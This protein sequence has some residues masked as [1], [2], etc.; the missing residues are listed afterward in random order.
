VNALQRRI[1]SNPLPP[2]AVSVGIGLV[3]GGLSQYGFLAVATHA[4]GT[5]RSAPL[6]T[7]WAL[8]VIIGPGFFL[9]IEQEIGSALAARRARGAGGRPV[10]LRAAASGGAILAGL[11]VAAIAASGPVAQKLFA[12]QLVLSWALIAG[13]VAYFVQFLGR[14]TLAGNGRFRPY[15]AIVGGEGILRVVFCAGLAG[16]GAVTAG[17]FGLAMVAGSFVAVIVALTGRRGLLQPGPP[18][19]WSEISSALGFLLIAS[20]MTQFLLSVGTVAV[21]LLAAPAQQAAAGRFLTSRIIAYIPIFLFQAVQY[22]LLPKLAALAGVGRYG[23]FVK[24]LRQILGL[25][26][27]IGAAAVLV[28]TVVGPWATRLL[29]GRGFELTQ[30]DFL[31]LS[32]SCAG[33]MAAQVLSQALISLRGFARVA[34]GW[35]SGGAAFVVVTALGTQL[36]LR[37]ELG[38]V[39]AAIACCAVMAGAL[40]PLLRSRAAER[41][42]APLA[43][44]IAV[45]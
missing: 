31:L 13:L 18:A 4:L 7:F 38:L 40:L 42:E 1:A 26:A 9:P 39:V 33:F 8:L 28:L 5:D 43:A 17:P 20:V 35:L 11:V 29:F 15:G 21:Q 10:V 34:A 36:F 22:T 24:T 41:V 27:A 16:V 32:A 12:G 6:A 37:V 30:L 3:I 25:V 45:Q 23:E 2:G 19:A 14:G 44:R